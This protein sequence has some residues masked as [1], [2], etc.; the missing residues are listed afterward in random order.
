MERKLSITQATEECRCNSCYAQNYDS[1]NKLD[2]RVD[3]IFE[4][5]I[6]NFCNRLCP[7]CLDELVRHAAVAQ[8]ARLNQK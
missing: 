5:H 8:G 1:D 4:V 7:E 6:G 3:V 2:S